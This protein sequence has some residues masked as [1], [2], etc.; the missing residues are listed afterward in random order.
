MKR[1]IFK[2]ICGIGILGSLCACKNSSID[3]PDYQEGTTAYFAYQYPIRTIVLG[4]DEPDLTLDHA[5]KC[6]IQA[7]FG[8]SYN[9]S[10]GVVQVAV[11]ESLCN[12]LFFDD[13][14]TPV[15]AMPSS[16]YQLSTTSL[17]YN[18]TMKGVTEVQLTDA[19][20]NDPDAVKETY[21][22]PLV[23]TGQ[24]GFD[25]ILEGKLNEGQTGPR[26]NAEAWDVLPMDY[27]LYCVKY[28]NKYSGWWLTHH[29]TDTSDIEHAQT[30]QIK[31][32]SL[33]SCSYAVSFQDENQIYEADLLLTFDG[34]ENCT[35]SSVADG[36]TVTG[37]GKWGDD[38]EKK[39]WGDKDRDG[40]ELDYKVSFADGKS[41]STHE[42]LVWQRSGVIPVNEFSPIYIK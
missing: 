20:F 22:I 35:I 19:F 26:T 41:F 29:T 36:L 4:D 33:N 30:V 14:V 17:A 34:S 38:S 11:D 1:N 31:T 32:V 16:Y 9:G 6:Q 21:V 12:N 13:G 3:F 2:L 25:H 10:N 28:Q 39:A 42:K 15:K 27:V 5:H 40:L 18:G 37:T 7:T 8:G 23:M 24:T